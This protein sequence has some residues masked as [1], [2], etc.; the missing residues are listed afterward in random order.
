MKMNKL[1]QYII[2]F[3]VFVFIYGFIIVCFGLLVVIIVFI[4]NKILLL[5]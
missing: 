2:K 4:I 5:K 3:F 1:K